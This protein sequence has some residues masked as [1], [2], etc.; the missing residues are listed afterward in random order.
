MKPLALAILIA[1]AAAAATTPSGNPL[2]SQF[3]VHGL[4]IYL[5][6]FHPL[7]DEPSHQMEAHHFCKH[8][9]EDFLQCALFDGNGKDANLNGIE[10][11]IS[12]KLYDGLSKEEQA[13]WHPHNYEILS[14]QLV[15]PNLP[16]NAEKNLMKREMN[17]YGKTWHVWM[18]ASADGKGDAL[19]LG[20]PRLAWSLNHDG[21]SKP[22]LLERRDKTLKID[23]AKKRAD[24]QDLL[25]LAHPQRGV[26]ALKFS[27]IQ[28][29][30]GVLDKDA[31]P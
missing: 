19:P 10:Y 27:N 15:A 31:S 17:S 7:K 8:V 13:Y 2:Q 20:P 28:P 24:R 1:C 25:P 29:I 16:D 18:T 4:D 11:I 5:V 26:D 23:S 14:G 3:P 12:E 9:N 6:G 21:E 30:K 22:N